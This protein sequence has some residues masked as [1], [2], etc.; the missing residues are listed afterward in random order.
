MVNHSGEYKFQYRHPKNTK[1][2]P[3][4][5]HRPSH[6]QL[7][8][9]SV[10]YESVQPHHMVHLTI[11]GAI[12]LQLKILIKCH[13]VSGGIPLQNVYLLDIGSVAVLPLYEDNGTKY[14]QERLWRC[15]INTSVVHDRK[16]IHVVGRKISQWFLKQMSSHACA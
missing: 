12:G 16:N 4:M 9:L 8:Q 6:T 3:K 1:I 13:H 11:D 5:P 7:L 15:G 2:H 14:V 10:A